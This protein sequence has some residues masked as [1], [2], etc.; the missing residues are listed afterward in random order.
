MLVLGGREDM[1]KI[2]CV[3][4][5]KTVSRRKLT[6]PNLMIF[7]LNGD[8]DMIDQVGIQRGI[9]NLLDR[10]SDLSLPLEIFVRRKHVCL[11][12]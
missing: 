4:S 8:G 11:F 5:R 10:L 3:S 6:V 7:K 1:P 2:F 12:S 9:P